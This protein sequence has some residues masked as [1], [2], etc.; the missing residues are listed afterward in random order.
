M[1]RWV[2]FTAILFLLALTAGCPYTAKAPLGDPDRNSFDK[3]LVGTWM[4]WDPGNE[5]DSTLIRILPFNDAEYY[6]EVEEQDKEPS[7]YRAY[8]ITIGEQKFLQLNELADHGEALEYCFARCAFSGNG[9]LS[10]RFVG[11]KIVPKALSMDPKS[12]KAFL[13]SHL[14]DPALDDE[15]VKLVLKKRS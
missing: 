9:D 1:K 12:L 6:I 10:M 3:R 8:M 11:E 7:R 2:G 5:A 14:G 13:A 15:D 4:G